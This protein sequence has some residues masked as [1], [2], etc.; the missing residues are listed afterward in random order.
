M[1]VSRKEGQKWPIIAM[2]IYMILYT[3]SG[4]RIST[5]ILL[6][7]TLYVQSKLFSKI[8]FKSL[9]K[10]VALAL[11]VLFVF[12]MV[13]SARSNIKS[14]NDVIS[15][16][17]NSKDTLI[18]NNYLVATISEA[19]YTFEATA[20]VLDNCPSN[21]PFHHGKSYISGLLYILPNGITGNYYVATKSTDETFKKYLNFYGSGIGS[22][23]IAEAYWNFGYYSWILM[24]VF[25]FLIGKM[26]V[27]LD[28]AIKKRDYLLIFTNAYIFSIVAF[29]IRSDTRT[30]FRNFVWFGLPIIIVVYYLRNRSRKS[31]V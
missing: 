29:Y 3:L 2:A 25:G 13:S 4:S 1:F 31:I 6:L 21:E 8:N 20:T 27:S 5:M 10:F 9:I 24:I 17:N 22:S 23:F 14:G 7:S 19:G 15:V 28:L 16:L 26:S 12:G 18:E 30:F 11:I